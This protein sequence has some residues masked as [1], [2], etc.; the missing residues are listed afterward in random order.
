MVPN[1]F[2]IRDVKDGVE[3]YVGGISTEDAVA[4]FPPEASAQISNY[5]AAPPGGGW[6]SAADL[7]V[8]KTVDDILKVLRERKGDNLI[9]FEATIGEVT[10]SSHDDSEASLRFPTREG[11]LSYLSATAEPSVANTLVEMV[12]MNQDRYVAIVDGRCVIY[13]TF[14]DYLSRA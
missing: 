8:A 7:S 5:A 3:I 12:S 10:L 4:V 11:A 14:D 2:L 13:D 9:D 6:I 1:C